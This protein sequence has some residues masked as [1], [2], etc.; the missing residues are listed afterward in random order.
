MTAKPGPHRINLQWTPDRMER[1]FVLIDGRG[2]PQMLCVACRKGRMTANIAL[3][4]AVDAPEGA[5]EPVSPRA[6]SGVLAGPP[7][8]AL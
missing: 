7:E 1:P 6:G 3:A 4:L 2:M 8:E 5:R